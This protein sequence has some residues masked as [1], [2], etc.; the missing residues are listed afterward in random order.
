MAQENSYQIEQFDPEVLR[1]YDIRGIVDKNIT[2]NT[3]YTI[4]R[5]FG[6]IVFEKLKSNN[7]SL[8]YDGRLTSPKLYKALSTGLKDAGANVKSIG[9]CPTPL[10]Y[11]A[12]YYLKTD[13]ALM[14]TGSHNPSEY[15][16]F[17]M[18]M[19]KHSFYSENIQKFKTI[20]KTIKLE[21]KEGSVEHIDII[22]AYVE[23]VLKNI[24]LNFF[25]SEV[26]GISNSNIT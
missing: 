8:G 24:S 13:A 2:E 4:G 3:A 26:I 7:I 11:F 16:G 12:D 23:R 6:Y 9:M 5:V 21:K 22:D 17:K 1:E 15:N 20:L 25:I 19:N 18:V 10:L 14:I